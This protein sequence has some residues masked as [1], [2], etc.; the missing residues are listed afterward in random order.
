M[1]LRAADQADGLRE[2]RGDIERAVT[3]RRQK[4]SSTR[5]IAVT[6]GK[7]G[8]GKTQIA[9]NLAVGMARRGLSVVL[10]D[11]DLGL[12]SLDLALGLT[13][14]WDM[15]AVVD[16][17]KRIEEI[18]V[19]G[20]GGV[21][22]LPACP[23][24]YEMANLGPSDRNAIANAVDDLSCGFDLLVIDTGAGIGGN[25]VSFASFADDVLLVTTPDPTSVRDA[26][27]MTKILNRRG[28]LDRIQL[29]ANQVSSEAEGVELHS[30]LLAIVRRFLTLELEYLGCVPADDSV[31]QAVAAR[32]PFLLRAPQSAAARATEALVRRLDTRAPARQPCS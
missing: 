2:A 18:L 8:V 7:G 1:A 10:F 32:E 3:L 31:R 27:A 23:G 17:D 29:V 28:G 24:R 11:A 30:C 25:A 14:R 12:A 16:G 15:R 19:E 21:K 9:A 20:P 5:T 13:P 26:Y 4:T 22:L 6:S